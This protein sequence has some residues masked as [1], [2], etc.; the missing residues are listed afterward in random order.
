VHVKIDI[1][2]LVHGRPAHGVALGGRAPAAFICHL[3]HMP[4]VQSPPCA[5]DAAANNK[6][7]VDAVNLHLLQQLLGLLEPNRR[8]RS[9]TNLR[10][11][12]LER[13]PSNAHHQMRDLEHATPVP[14]ALCSCMHFGPTCPGLR[15]RR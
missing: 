12:D 15:A 8:Q 10:P 11:F 2:Q 5:Q 6:H 13:A 9:D 14:A 4:L 1:V 3:L 7:M